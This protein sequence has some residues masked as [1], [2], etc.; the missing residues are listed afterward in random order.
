VQEMA[1]CPVLN[2]QH[3]RSISVE[4][5]IDGLFLT[6]RCWAEKRVKATA[7]TAEPGTRQFSCCFHPTSTEVLR[8]CFSVVAE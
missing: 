5:W 8:T 1:G 7:C 3:S 2:R 4:A 6:S